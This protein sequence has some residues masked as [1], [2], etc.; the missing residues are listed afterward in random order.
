MARVYNPEQDWLFEKLL[1]KLN[2]HRNVI[3][4]AA[5]GWGVQ[6]YVD[7]L[8]FQLSEKYPDMQTCFIDLRP[9]QSATSFLELFASALLHRFP[10]ETS[11]I[12]IDYSSV[13]TLKLPEVIARSHK[14]RIAIFVANS[15]LF[16]RFKDPNSFLRMLKMKLKNQKNSVFC[17]YGNSSTN[18]GDLLNHPGPLSGLGQ[19]FELEHN[20][21]KHRSASIRKL[22]YDHKKQIGYS[23]SVQMSYAVDNNPFYLKLLAW[24]TLLMTQN[25]CTAEIVEKSLNNLIHHFDHRFY[26]LVESLTI[27]QLGFLKA[28]V[29]GNRK[30]YSKSIRDKYQLGSTSNIARIKTSLEKKEIIQTVRTE[31]LFTDPIFRD[32]LRKRYFDKSRMTAANS[33]LST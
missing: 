2:S 24:H 20:P 6:E 23:T 8:R 7:E 29:D 4:T 31:T 30:L 17:F 16:H 15:H 11:S 27:K 14:I 3:L 19:L 18:F 1:R 21:M 10:K 13:D 25:I 5:L 12:K 33:S 22:F 28:L 9:V 26:L 32:W